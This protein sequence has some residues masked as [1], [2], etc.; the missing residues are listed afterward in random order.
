MLVWF[1]VC[2]C[3][4]VCVCLCV[5]VCVLCFVLRFKALAQH[6]TSTDLNAWIRRGM[7]RFSLGLVF[8]LSF[9]CG[10]DCVFCCADNRKSLGAGERSQ[11]KV[12]FCCFIFGGETNSSGEVIFF[13]FFFF[14]NIQTISPTWD[15]PIK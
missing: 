13:F 10:A 1:C 15:K 4:L 9:L 12:F 2:V 14:L 11:A 7:L 8:P 6:I 3:V 5:Y